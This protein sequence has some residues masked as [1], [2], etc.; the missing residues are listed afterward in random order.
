MGGRINTILEEAPN[1]YIRF[2]VAWVYSF[3]SPERIHFNS[4]KILVFFDDTPH[5]GIMTAGCQRSVF[6]KFFH[7]IL[8]DYLWMAGN[9]KVLWS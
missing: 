3:K 9:G 1:T 7:H 5:L 4:I 6:K 8:L 2:S